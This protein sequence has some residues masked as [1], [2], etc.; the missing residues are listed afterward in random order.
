M[1]K[2]TIFLALI[3]VLAGNLKIN[4]QTPDW[5]TV[6]APLIYN[7]CSSCHHSGGIGPFPLMSYSDAVMNAAGIQLKVVNREMPPWPADPSYRHFAYEALL[8]SS[9]IAAISDWV[10]IGMPLGDTT[11][12]PAPPVFSQTGSLLDTINMTLQIPP[13]IL[14]YSTDEYRY[15]AMHSG[16]TDTIYVSKI[17][18]FP[19]LPH[20]VHH[21]DIHYDLTGVSFYND[22]IT[23][24]P[25]FSG[26][27]ASSYYMN[28]WQ[29]GGNI[30]EYPPNWGIMVPPGADFVFEIHYGPGHLGETDTTKMNL[31]F[32][33]MAALSALFMW[34]GCLIIPFRHRVRL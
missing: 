17:E 14:Q 11:L 18:V 10:D 8:D 19:G 16:F 26:G 32:I 7:N 34:D 29:P 24:L 3:F 13:Y 31:Q 27:G 15:F 33:P 4:A 25:G 12:A 1:L 9:E 6:V 20:A 21:A 28:A 22:S 5:S 2:Q 30:V 23:P